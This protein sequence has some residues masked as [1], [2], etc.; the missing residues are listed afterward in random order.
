MTRICGG[1][2]AFFSFYMASKITRATHPACATPA[3]LYYFR[4]GWEASNIGELTRR[5]VL[6]LSLLFSSALTEKV[7]RGPFAVVDELDVFFR[8]VIFFFVR[9]LPLT[10]EFRVGG[11]VGFWIIWLAG[12]CGSMRREQFNV[13]LIDRCDD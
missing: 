13:K 2:F 4:S 1:F 8:G 9:S 12:Y 10:N 7:W 6:S 5:R 3:S 11:L